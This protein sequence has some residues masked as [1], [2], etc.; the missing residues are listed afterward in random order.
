[1]KTD[2]LAP[3]TLPFPVTRAVAEPITAR[4]EGEGMPTMV[5]HF[6]TFDQWYEVDSMLEGRFM[7]RIDPSAFDKTIAANRSSMKV[8]YDHGQ[9]PQIGN[10]ILGPIEDLSTDATGPKEET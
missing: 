9:D 7:E 6:A 1:M 8:L 3:A 10:K 4:A 2:N 5:G